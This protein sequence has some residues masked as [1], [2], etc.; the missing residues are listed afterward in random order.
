ME[1]ELPAGV[2]EL[3]LFTGEASAGNLRLYARAGNT[4]TDRQPT[5]AGYSLVHMSRERG[6]S[7]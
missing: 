6:P 3:R 2:T 1:A 4:E 5:A 7:R